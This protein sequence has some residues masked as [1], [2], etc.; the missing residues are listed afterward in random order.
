FNEVGDYTSYLEYSSK[1][2]S[3]DEHDQKALYGLC[4]S[5]VKLGNYQE[6]LNYCIKYISEY[7][8][9]TNI[10]NLTG[11]CYEETSLNDNALTCYQK[12]CALNPNNYESYKNMAHVYF[13]MENYPRTIENYEK[14]KILNE[15]SL[16]LENILE[17]GK[18]YEKIDRY[19]RAIQYLSLY[20]EEKTDDADTVYSLGMLHKKDG[21]FEKASDYLRQVA[22]LDLENASIWK[23][24]AECYIQI[25]KFEKAMDCLK[26]SLKISPKQPKAVFDLGLCLQETGQYEKAIEFLLK[27]SKYDPQDSES[28]HRIGACYHELL[29][30]Q[31]SIEYYNKALKIDPNKFKTLHN[32][33]IVYYT[34]S[35]Y[36]DSI[37][38]LKKALMV[39]PDDAITWFTLGS[40]YYKLSEF[41]NAEKSYINAISIAKDNKDFKISLAITLSKNKK[42]EQAIRLFNDLKEQYPT[43]TEILRNIAEIYADMKRYFDA[44]IAYK[45][46]IAIKP[47]LENEINNIINKVLLD[48]KDSNT[49]IFHYEA[50]LKENPQDYVTWTKLG[51]V[52]TNLKEFEKAKNCFKKALQLNPDYYQAKHGEILIFQAQGQSFEAVIPLKKLSRDY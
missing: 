43:N 17:L 50:K 47:E 7:Q 4:K 38:I 21:N 9:D 42:F 19:E 27:Y 35:A 49:L 16:D 36:Q 20:L 12:A 30:P 29:D 22:K 23:E 18:A 26:R 3:I 37:D 1:I 14:S 41:D 39:K 8:D 15:K 52:Q 13:K 51:R 25:R 45:E 6:A 32:I 5:N 34:T 10:L 24:L 46:I 11:K 40:S 2:F 44:V 48:S 33:G 31:Q 28:L